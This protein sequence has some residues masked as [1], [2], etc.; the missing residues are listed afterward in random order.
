MHRDEKVMTCLGGKRS[1]QQTIEYMEHNL[2]HWDE[3]GYEIWMLR[4]NE[5]V[6]FVGR[7]GQRNA[8]FDGKD[9]VKVAYGLMPEFWNK[10][11]ATE[12]VRAVI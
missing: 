11:L 9:E 10:G 4:E 1:Q 7:G 8:V 3:H 12:F 2:A 6:L 5:T